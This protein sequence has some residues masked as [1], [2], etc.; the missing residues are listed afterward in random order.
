MVNEGKVL[1]QALVSEK[2]TDI[3]EKQNCYVFKVSLMANKLDI[4]KAVEK[5]FNVKVASVTTLNVKG[6]TKKLGRFVGKRSSWKK[7]FVSLKEG[8]TIE[9]FESV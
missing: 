7:A 6:K 8:D 5:A 3:Q 4:K 2:A 9:L 1:I